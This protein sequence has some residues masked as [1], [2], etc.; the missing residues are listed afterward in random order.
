[1]Q[2]DSSGAEYAFDWLTY[3]RHGSCGTTT[4]LVSSMAATYGLSAA[5]MAFTL[6]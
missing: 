2:F 4:V 5:A 1:M 6:A 3:A